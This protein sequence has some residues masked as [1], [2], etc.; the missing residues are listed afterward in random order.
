MVYREVRNGQAW[1]AAADIW[2]LGVCFYEYL[3]GGDLPLQLTD[4]NLT[5]P[6]ND[7]HEGKPNPTINYLTAGCITDFAGSFDMLSAFAE[8]PGAWALISSMLNPDPSQRPT[9]TQVMNNTWLTQGGERTRIPPDY[10]GGFNRQCMP[11][12]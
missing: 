6:L 1:S 7:I 3:T 4:N 2:A 10:E 9:I 12:C 5:Q 8:V 11:L